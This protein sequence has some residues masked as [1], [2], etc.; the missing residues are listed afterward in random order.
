MI[1][2]GKLKRVL[3]KQQQFKPSRDQAISYAKTP[4]ECYGKLKPEELRPLIQQDV[5]AFLASGG[6]IQTIPAGVGALTED[7]E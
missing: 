7:D 1:V 2:D 6:K 3:T 4:K 5:E